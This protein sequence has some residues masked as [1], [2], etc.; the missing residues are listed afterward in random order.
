MRTGEER[1]EQGLLVRES[2]LFEKHET[3]TA[4][5]QSAKDHGKANSAQM[6]PQDR[7]STRSFA[8]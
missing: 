4:T 5:F 1:G 3:E 8:S 2:G 6:R 7:I